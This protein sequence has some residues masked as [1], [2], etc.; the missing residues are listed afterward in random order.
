MQ[1]SDRK[2]FRKSI[3]EEPVDGAHMAEKAMGNESWKAVM[4]VI[5]AMHAMRIQ[6]K[7]WKTCQ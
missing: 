5:A 6:V 2:A 7:T 3:Y 4:P 1:V